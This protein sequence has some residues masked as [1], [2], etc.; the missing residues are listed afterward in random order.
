MS[1]EFIDKD[2]VFVN[3]ANRTSGTSSNFIFDLSN[4][5]KPLNEYDSVSLLSFTCPKSYY[6]F[7]ETNNTFSVNED[8]KITN[9]TIPVGNYSFIGPI[10]ILSNILQ[11]LL[12]PCAWTYTVSS[13]TVKGKFVF[14]VSGNGGKQPIFNFSSS[15]C[16]KILGFDKT[17][18][19]FSGNTLTSSGIVNFQKTN[20][21]QLCC[22]FVE[23]SILSIII[24]DVSDFSTINYNEYNTQFVSR[25]LSRSNFSVSKFYL[26]DGA[27]GTPL[28][29]NN[30]DF[31]FT[32]VIYKKNDYLPS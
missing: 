31:N 9:I 18:Y 7:N 13:D 3:S 2:V 28:D 14:N 26:L 25:P 24:P 19:T 23:K 8:G 27:T 10:D 5:I 29:L 16:C 11:T 20:T 15:L 6:L 17:S 30:I 21:I 32:F 12:F 4:Q 1:S 22:D